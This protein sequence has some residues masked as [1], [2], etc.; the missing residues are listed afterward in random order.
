MWH[1]LC[2]PVDFVPLC[3]CVCVCVCVFVLSCSVMPHVAHQA[4]LSMEFSRQAYWSGLSF[5]SPQDLPDPGIELKSL[6]SP[7]LAGG[8]LTTVPPGKPNFVIPNKYIKK[9]N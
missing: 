3:V 5:P 8:F 7:V 1:T 4:A 9:K 2:L 6:V